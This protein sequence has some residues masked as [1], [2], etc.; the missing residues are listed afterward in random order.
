MAL[1]KVGT[2]VLQKAVDYPFCGN[3]GVVVIDENPKLSNGMVGVDFGVYLSEDM[4]TY[5][6]ETHKL[7]GQLE[8][9]TGYFF[10]KECLKPFDTTSG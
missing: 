2:K 4:G 7:D 1:I 3:V 8:K 9:S 5:S 10:F 6:A